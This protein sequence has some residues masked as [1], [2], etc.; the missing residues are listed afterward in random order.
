[1]IRDAAVQSHNAVLIPCLY[2]HMLVIRDRSYS[3]RLSAK[4]LW[5]HPFHI[6]VTV[7]RSWLVVIERDGK[8]LYRE[9][10][11]LSWW[12]ADSFWFLLTRGITRSLLKQATSECDFYTRNALYHLNFYKDTDV[13][14]P[15]CFDSMHGW[16]EMLIICTHQHVVPFLK[17]LR[18][19]YDEFVV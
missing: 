13:V 9:A 5:A 8:T 6:I 14:T 18:L 1:M 7:K 17:N 15:T 4:T 2:Y 10:T 3:S 16:I 19:L 11:I 12:N